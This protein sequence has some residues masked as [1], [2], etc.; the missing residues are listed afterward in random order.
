MKVHLVEPLGRGGIFQHSVELARG[1]ASG[2]LTVVIHS[3]SDY[4]RLKLVEGVKICGC[5]DWFREDRNWFSRRLRFVSSYLFSSLRHLR[6]ATAGELVHV[7]GCFA[8]PLYFVSLAA[9]HHRS[10]RLIFSPHNTFSRGGKSWE[11]RLIPVA[12]R[13]FAD[14]VVAFSEADAIR[15]KRW[16]VGA[17]CLP[18]VQVQPDLTSAQIEQWK[19]RLNIGDELPIVL[20][21]GQIRSDKGIDTVLEAVRNLNIDV[22]LAVLGED[23]GDLARVKDL[24]DQLGVTVAWEVGYFDLDDFAAAIAAAD[25]VAVAYEQASQSGVLSLASALGT[26]SVA[27]PVGGLSEFAT[28][29]SDA[30]DAI[31]F[32]KALTTALAH[33]SLMECATHNAGLG[34]RQ[35]PIVNAYDSE[36][37]AR[38]RSMYMP[39]GRT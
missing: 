32:S 14:E 16:G 2:G 21:P 29:T 7:Q 18:L 4:E 17:Q 39:R 5:V 26:V 38:T 31:S 1:L 35:I 30:T 36:V 19:Q 10:A 6:N 27:T 24:A 23:K 28:F 15:M 33:S 12:A 9:L 13:N 8:S 22:Q 11:E 37:W 3:A 34:E 25:V 20:V